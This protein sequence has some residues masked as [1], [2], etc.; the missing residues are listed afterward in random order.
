MRT[1]TKARVETNALDEFVKQI[2]SK[3]KAQ[4]T[5]AR[6]AALRDGQAQ[7]VM[8]SQARQWWTDLRAWL[9]EFC[10][11]SNRDLGEEMFVF[12]LTPKWQ[13]RVHTKAPKGRVHTL[14]AH[15]NQ[16]LNQIFY[17]AG[18]KGARF[19]PHCA[20]DGTI[21]FTD[22]SRSNSVDRAGRTLID[23]LLDEESS[24]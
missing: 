6:M 8:P 10:E 23:A 24:K 4:E 3:L 19:T 11:K 18:S 22:V 16:K 1:E 17:S 7:E 15:F 21:E 13:V 12:E 5:Q 2:T 20:G 14:E 9:K